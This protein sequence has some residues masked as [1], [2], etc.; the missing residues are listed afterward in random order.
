MDEAA[1]QRLRYKA[2]PV[3]PP[4]LQQGPYIQTSDYLPY[5][6]Q[7]IQGSGSYISP[8]IYRWYTLDPPIWWD[9]LRPLLF[10]ALGGGAAIGSWTGASRRAA[11]FTAENAHRKPNTVKGWWYYKRVSTSSHLSQTSA[12]AHGECSRCAG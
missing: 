8:L 9:N 5:Q 4:L 11:R 3:L 2:H 1:V 6:D 10:P 12:M 7:V